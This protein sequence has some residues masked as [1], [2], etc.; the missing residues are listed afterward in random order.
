MSDTLFDLEIEWAPLY[1]PF[2]L[3]L[4]SLML[5]DRCRDCGIEGHNTEHFCQGSREAGTFVLCDVCAALDPHW[6]I[7][8]SDR[9]ELLATQED[10]R[11]RY[12]RKVHV[13]TEQ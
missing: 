3:T 13:S 9:D 12:L 7:R 5:P 8:V 11:R 2:G 6:G 4:L 1:K 10:R